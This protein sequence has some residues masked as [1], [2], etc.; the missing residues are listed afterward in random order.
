MRSP[1][2]RVRRRSSPGHAG[3]TYASDGKGQVLWYC[4]PDGGKN[5]RCGS[6]PQ[7]IRYWAQSGSKPP[8]DDQFTFRT[9]DAPL[10]W[11]KIEVNS[12]GEE[13]DEQEDQQRRSNC[14]SV[15]SGG[16][17]NYRVEGTSGSNSSVEGLSGSS[18]A[19]EQARRGRSQDT[20]TQHTGIPRAGEGVP[21][22]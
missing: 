10:H 8:K 11:K 1:V 5:D 14:A 17:E 7:L 6:K 15:G 4:P 22:E 18:P 9:V 2:R 13:E 19:D 3:W 20:G 12:D 21:D 16:D